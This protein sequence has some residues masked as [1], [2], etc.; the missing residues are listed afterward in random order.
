MKWFQ[1]MVHFTYNIVVFPSDDNALRNH[2]NSVNTRIQHHVASAHA[3]AVQY[4]PLQS[5][6]KYS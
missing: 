2:D 3:C 4:G 6:R 5:T 1:K